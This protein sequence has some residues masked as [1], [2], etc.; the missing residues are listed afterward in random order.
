MTPSG[1]TVQGASPEML[2]EL[3]DAYSFEVQRQDRDFWSTFQTGLSRAEIVDR[4]QAVDL[5]APEELLTWWTWRN[6]FRTGVNPDVTLPQ[7]SL[8]FALK[9]RDKDEM[10]LEEDEWNPAWIRVA[11]YSSQ[12]AMAVRCV[13]GE[14]VLVRATSADDSGTQDHETSRQV[15]SLCTPVSWWLLGIAK[16]WSHWDGKFWAIDQ[17]LFPYEWQLT[18]LLS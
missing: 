12:D 8:E 2:L 10:G 5:E 17:S 15:V 18:D 7:M 11:G 9:L 16:G 1:L 13:P 14:Q 3:L 4:L 6:G